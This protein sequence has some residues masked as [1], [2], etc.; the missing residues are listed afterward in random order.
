MY[1]EIAAI[2]TN[3]CF[4]FSFILA[5][6]IENEATPIFQ[7]AI[8]AT[9][10]LLTFF[11]I[12]LSFG[13]LLLVFSLSLFLILMLMMSVLF[14]VILGDTA[15]LHSQ[16]ILGPAKALAITTTSPF[17]TII[18]ATLFLNRPFSILMIFSGVLI[19]IGVIIITKE[20]TKKISNDTNPSFKNH[21]YGNQNKIKDKISLN[22][23]KGTLWATVAAVSWAIG[24]ALS[25]FSV[26]QV[27]LVLNLGI[28]STM[29]AMMIR[30]LFAASVLSIIALIEG[31]KQ[32][33]LKSRNT[34]KILIISAILSYS[35]GSLFFG[36]AVHI[37]GAS[38][39]SL[40]STALPLFTIPFSYIIN[41]EKISK[42]GFLGVI[43]TLIG[44]ILILF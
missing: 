10:G 29:I 39:M 5:R 1:G 43:I 42:K 19:G 33:I 24:I 20:K 18:F 9:V 14:T 17:F 28:L 38:F 34:W 35:I 8:K 31:E 26:N 30:F 40:I 11:I 36:E 16:K 37:A 6:R 21:N 32:P 41:K 15:Y 2:L 44:V 12:C 3:V 22:T 27:N 13:V 25:D 4:A 23:L 7:N